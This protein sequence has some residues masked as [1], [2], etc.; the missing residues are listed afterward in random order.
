M[1]VILL[2]LEDLTCSNWWQGKDHN[3]QTHLKQLY[4]RS[5]CLHLYRY[6]DGY[7]TKEVPVW[8]QPNLPGDQV[9]RKG[10]LKPDGWGYTPPPPPPPPPLALP[11]PHSSQHDS[12][13]VYIYIC[14]W[15]MTGPTRTL[16]HASL[17]VLYGYVDIYVVYIHV[18]I[19][20]Y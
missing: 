10:R 19:D 11:P 8:G 5:H 3:S 4:I 9:P 2:A 16:W 6:L 7:I 20:I 12:I 17:C 13:H 15:H 1:P 18:C 14:P